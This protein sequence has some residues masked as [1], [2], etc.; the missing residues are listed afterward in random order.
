LTTFDDHRDA[1]SR[2][3]LLREG[4]A[5]LDAEINDLAEQ[6][7]ALE[8]VGN[9]GRN[10]G[11]IAERKRRKARKKEIEL[12]NINAEIDRLKAE[13]GDEP[14]MT[15]DAIVSPELRGRTVSI[16]DATLGR[17][18]P[19]SGND[20]RARALNTIEAASALPDAARQALTLTV[21]R[22][23]DPDS[24]LARWINVAG[25]PAYRS[26]FFKLMRDPVNGHREFTDAELGAYQR[27]QN[28]ARVLGLGAQGGGFM[29][30]LEVDPQILI[31]SAGS[32]DPMRRLA[33]VVQ[34]AENKRQFVTSAG[35]TASWDAESAEV[36]DDS[37]TLLGPA[38]DVFKGAAFVPTSWEHASDTEIATEVGKLL[39][40]AKV[41]LEATAFTLGTGTGQPKGVITA[42][43]AVGGSVIATA[44]NVLAQAD[45]YNNQ[46]ALPARWR[47]NAKFAMNLSILNGYRQLPQATGLNY[48]I[49]NDDGP[50]PKALGWEIHENSVMDGTLNASSADYT[51]LSGDFQ[52]YAIVDRIGAQIEYVPHLFGS[53]RRPTNEVGF[54]L[55]WRT[56]GDVLIADAFRLTNHSG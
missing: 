56:G 24:K 34:T 29:T 22:D 44:T 35:V 28:E 23:H 5:I 26:A 17:T 51:V 50:I 21:E 49:I 25:D 12:E 27:V 37:P 3:T 11:E 18:S 15:R 8:T 9:G 6:I 10:A 13:V 4:R 31:S 1:R 32:V 45:L 40:D 46:A 36:S 30:T 47:P 42:V 53:N 16:E 19:R 14:R 54:L 39:L 55:R 52:Q 33:R 7:A 43:S 38:V 2:L 20:L 48:S 41:Q